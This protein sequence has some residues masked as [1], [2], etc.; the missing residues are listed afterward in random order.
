MKIEHLDTEFKKAQPAIMGFFKDLDL[1]TK[2]L[3][4]LKRANFKN[5]DISILTIKKKDFEKNILEGV[6]TGAIAG[7]TE[8]GI[9]CWLVSLGVITIPGAGTFIAAGPFVSAV[10]GAALG[11]NVGCIAGALIGFGVAEVEAK[12]LEKFIKEK[13]LI[14]AVH[15]SDPK[16]LLK[17]KNVFLSNKAIKVFDPLEDNKPSSDQSANMI[18]NSEVPSLNSEYYNLS[19]EVPGKYTRVFSKKIPWKMIISLT[20]LQPD[21]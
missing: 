18:K 11:L 4:D 20:V 12:E 19:E 16:D 6:A 21:A 9:L 13:G 15:V 8:G 1:L 14:V 7:V 10:A 3:E 2:I 17:A 5:E